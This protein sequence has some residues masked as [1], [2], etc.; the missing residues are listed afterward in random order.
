MLVSEFLDGSMPCDW[1]AR[2][3]YLFLDNGVEMLDLM[4]TFGSLVIFSS[5]NN[6]FIDIL[7]SLL[8]SLILSFVYYLLLLDLLLFAFEMLFTDLD[9]LASMVLHIL[10]FFDH[11]DLLMRDNTIHDEINGGWHKFAD[12]DHV[13]FINVF[14]FEF[15]SCDTSCWNLFLLPHL[16]EMRVLYWVR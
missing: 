5:E 9:V 2:R 16:V 3:L 14:A 7:D 1:L 13:Y 12:F 8:H 6:F 10:G 4:I 15:V 11:F